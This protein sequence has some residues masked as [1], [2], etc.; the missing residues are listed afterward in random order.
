MK[1]AGRL[2]LRLLGRFFDDMVTGEE[3]QFAFKPVDDMKDKK[4]NK[5][6]KNG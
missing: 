4:S 5:K 2:V 6:H 1:F 3:N